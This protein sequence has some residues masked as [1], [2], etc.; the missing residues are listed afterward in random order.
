MGPKWFARMLLHF[1]HNLNIK[2]LKNCDWLLTTNPKLLYKTL[3]RFK[4]KLKGSITIMKDFPNAS[5][6]IQFYL[7]IILTSQR[8]DYMD[9]YRM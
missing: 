4:L 5:I 1:L 2:S 3:H 8:G 7:S 9:F 6:L